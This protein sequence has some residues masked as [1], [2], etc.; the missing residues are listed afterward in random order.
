MNIRPNGLGE[1]LGDVLATT[2]PLYCSGA[3][4]FVRSTIGSD[5]DTGLDHE[6]PFAT[7]A[8]AVATASAGDVICLLD[9]HT[10]TLAAAIAINK[11]LYIV[12][13]G[14]SGGK[15]TVSFLTSV[16]N[17]D[18][19]D[20]SAAHTEIRNILF[21]EPTVNAN[22]GA[23]GSKVS[24]SANGVRVIGCYFEMG[25]KDVGQYGLFLSAGVTDVRL[26]GTTFISTATN[27]ATRPYGALSFSGGGT[28]TD[29]EMDGVVFSDGTVGYQNP[30][31]DGAGRT[32]T[33]FRGM[34]LSLLLGAD[35]VIGTWTGFFATPT[36]TGGGRVVG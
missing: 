1:I 7:L 26:T 33:R 32:F 15:P 24:I 25:P 12:G 14:S 6:R 28:F 20:I 22:G 34:N 23:F 30:S 11:Q 19:F 35:M 13:G 5:V 21:K 27:S 16:G 17:Q 10:E 4:Y 29:F 18:I 2:K 9:G 3:V 8:H 31:F 36:T